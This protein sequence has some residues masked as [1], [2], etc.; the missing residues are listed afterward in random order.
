V[1]QP[2]RGGSLLEDGL[3]PKADRHLVAD[4]DA[5]TVHRDADVDAE[6]AAADLRGRG[7]AGA[8]AGDPPG[9]AWLPSADARLAGQL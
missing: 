6:V 9:M 8:A 3:D 7:E 2:V 5:T 4:R 1:R